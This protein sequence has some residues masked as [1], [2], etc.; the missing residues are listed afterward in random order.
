MRIKT[1]VF[2]GFSSIAIITLFMGIFTY[3]TYFDLVE[4]S[5]YHSYV[6]LP[7]INTISEIKGKLFESQSDALQYII[8]GDDSEKNEYLQTKYEMN[9][10]ITT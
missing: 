5:E 9:L 3:Y 6:E 8:S 4:I 1:R 2:M 7:A 10:L